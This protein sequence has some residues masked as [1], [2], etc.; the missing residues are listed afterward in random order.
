MK[1]M[2]LVFLAIGLSVSLF[3]QETQTSSE[4][5]PT[6]KFGLKAGLNLTNLYV[7]DVD[8]ENIK[9]GL[10]IGAYAKI[11]VTKHFSFQPEVLY[12]MKGAQVNYNNLLYSG[13]Y[14]FNLNYLEVPLAAV[15]NVAK[16]FNIQ[17]GPY[18]AFLLSAKVQDVD[19]NGNITGATELD[20]DDFESI[21]YGVFA[22][23]AFDISNVTLG[24]RYTYGLNEIGKTGLSGNITRDSKNSA[25]TFFLGFGF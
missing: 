13:K 12:S 8:D 14:R 10:S 3:A 24:A 1:K 20:K 15:I 5:K 2:T 18:A 16:N 7:N 6:P 4:T 23:A 21:D 11:P 9:P 22:G 25:I 17:A 19:D